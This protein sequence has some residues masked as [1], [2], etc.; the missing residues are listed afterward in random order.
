[1]KILGHIQK[2][3]NSK[4]LAALRLVRASARK[5]HIALDFFS[6]PY[7]SFLFKYAVSVVYKMNAM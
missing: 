7:C 3:S 5:K 6:C 1:M 2:F 4:D